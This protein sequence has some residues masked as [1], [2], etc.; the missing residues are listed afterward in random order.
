MC[1]SCGKPLPEGSRGRV[2]RFCNRACRGVWL[3]ARNAA[4][5]EVEMTVCAC[6]CGTPMPRV[7]HFRERRYVLG[8]NG[9]K[10]DTRVC[11][12]CGI[13]Y[14]A[15]R[16][17]LEFCSRACSSGTRVNEHRMV[18]SGAVYRRWR[19]GV[20][21]RDGSA[22]R[23]CGDKGPRLHAHHI[24]EF[25]KNPDL[26][27]VIENGIT[28]CAACHSWVHGRRLA[29]GVNLKSH[30]PHLLTPELVDLLLNPDNAS[31]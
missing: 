3:V 4:N 1:E 24:Q 13:E 11:Q 22:C 14:P 21:E 20:L 27:L 18:R 12:A 29:A 30:E 19:L 17:G 26:R 31:K 23:G 7:S 15:R 6:G 8:H 9:R 28:L 10:R 16:R 25:A 2:R 5:R